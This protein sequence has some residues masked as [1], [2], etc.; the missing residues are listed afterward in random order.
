ML[1]QREV[2]RQKKGEIKSYFSSRGFDWISFF[3]FCQVKSMFRAAALG[4]L[5]EA[6]RATFWLVQMARKSHS[7]YLFS[8]FST[9]LSLACG[10]SSIILECTYK[11]SLSLNPQFSG[12]SIFI[13]LGRSET[14]TK[15]IENFPIYLPSSRRVRRQ[16]EKSTIPSSSSQC[17]FGLSFYF[18]VS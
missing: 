17:H 7:Q 6:K 9:I 12:P 11:R 18:P 8:I 5:C 15:R 1:I 16:I 10:S 3:L 14:N 2:E 4:C 13:T